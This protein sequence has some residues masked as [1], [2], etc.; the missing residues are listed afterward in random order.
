M[1]I[2]RVGSISSQT[3]KAIRETSAEDWLKPLIP[4]GPEPKALEQVDA[5]L[6]AAAHFPGVE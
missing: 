4:E 5:A 2:T 1:D 3:I 6:F